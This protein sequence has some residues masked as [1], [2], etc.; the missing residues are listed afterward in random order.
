M[1]HWPL[2]KLLEGGG[3]TRS[4]EA[5]GAS[6]I[7]V[8]AEQPPEVEEAGLA[9]APG[10]S[11]CGSQGGAESPDSAA[12]YLPFCNPGQEVPGFWS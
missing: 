7:L 3:C 9:C 8:L 2:Q 5:L 6:R 11:V 12:D 4:P 10:S 1:G